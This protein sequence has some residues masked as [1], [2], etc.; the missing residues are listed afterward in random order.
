MP[1]VKRICK[2]CGKT[3]EACRTAIP[4]AFNWRDVACSKECAMIYMERIEES[5]RK[6]REARAAND[7]SQ[8]DTLNRWMD[9]AAAKNADVMNNMSPCQSHE[10][11]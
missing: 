6:E 11:D 4:G 8:D 1:R 2:Q 9:D 10:R 5:R 7:A 3:Y